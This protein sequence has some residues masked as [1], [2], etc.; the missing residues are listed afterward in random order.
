M[1]CIKCDNCGH[2]GDEAAFKPL[3]ESRGLLSRLTPGGIVPH[4]EC[5]K[6]GC[7]AYAV[8]KTESTNGDVSNQ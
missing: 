6:C 8:E 1:E 4:G 7:F 3:H 2:T 5:P